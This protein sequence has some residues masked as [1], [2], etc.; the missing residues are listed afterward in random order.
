MKKTTFADRLS[1]LLKQN[2]MTQKELAKQTG[3]TEASI[4]RYINGCRIPCGRNLC[5]IADVLNTTYDY[6]LG[7]EQYEDIS[8]D[9]RM[10][11]R[12]I[13]N[14]CYNFTNKQRKELINALLPDD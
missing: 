11:K 5:I 2:G 13:E 3:L 10:L 4:S 7:T 6:L 14:N 1:I 12:L 8:T 9:F